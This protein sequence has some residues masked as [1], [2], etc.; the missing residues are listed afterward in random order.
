MRRYEVISVRAQNAYIFDLGGRW[1]QD[2]ESVEY[3]HGHFQ[4]DSQIY[5]SPNANGILLIIKQIDTYI[6]GYSY[7]RSRISSG[8]DL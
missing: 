5:R 1:H 6:F 2:C 3:E 8:M 4:A 7:C